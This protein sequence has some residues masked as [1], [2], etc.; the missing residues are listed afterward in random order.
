MK[1]FNVNYMQT[2][3]LLPNLLDKESTWSYDPPHIDALI[4]ESQKM[5]HQYLKKWGYSTLPIYLLN[6]HTTSRE[7]EEL[8]CI[9][10]EKVGLISDAGLPCIADPGSSLVFLAHKKGIE[11]VAIPGPTSII[12]ALQLSGFNGQHF[13]F[14]GY[15]PREEHKCKKKLNTLEAH[16]THIFIETPYRTHKSFEKLL[17]SLNYQ[18]QLC[19]AL[20]LMSPHQ[21]VKTLRVGKWD[22]QGLP[23]GKLRALFLIQKHN[24]I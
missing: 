10:Q 18:D 24:R 20:E 17:K 12:M 7:I 15:L 9:K 4:A 8:I 14:H 11:V 16:C 13:T 22:A 2:L 5:G 6:E 3:F 23:K 1:Y 21:W 19:I